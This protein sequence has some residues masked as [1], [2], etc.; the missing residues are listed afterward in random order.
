M[1]HLTIVGMSLILLIVAG[2]TSPRAGREFRD[3]PIGIPY[4]PDNVYSVESLPTDFKRV[5]I[6]PFSLNRLDHDFMPG[7]EAAMINALRRQA[8]FEIVQVSADELYKLL[9]DDNLTF[10]KPIPVQLLEKI[11]AGY[12]A[13]GILQTEITAFRPY[14]P[15]LIG[16][17]TRLFTAAGD[18]ILWS[19]DEVFDAGNEKIAL[20]ARIHAE[21][22]L[23]Q[24]YPLQS[25]YSALISPQRFGSYVGHIMYK[26]LP[27]RTLTDDS[28]L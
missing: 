10:D 15:I 17:Q 11:Q 7:V 6:L 8:R 20:G 21:K 26:T 25:S 14:K 2:C 27:P 23:Q 16:V 3:M 4:K 22:E 9:G 13:D 19:C 5:V 24:P 1:K 28:S 12:G 18:R